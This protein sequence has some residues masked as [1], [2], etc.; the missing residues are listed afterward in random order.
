MIY[1]GT[2][3]QARSQAQVLGWRELA[4][5]VHCPSAGN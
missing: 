1:G 2:G 3:R 5:V 4:E